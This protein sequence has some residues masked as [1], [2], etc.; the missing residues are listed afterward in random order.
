MLRAVM[1]FHS[2]LKGYGSPPAREWRLKMSGVA[3]KNGGL[4]AAVLF[5]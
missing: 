5:I 3:W 1:A 4:I 2:A